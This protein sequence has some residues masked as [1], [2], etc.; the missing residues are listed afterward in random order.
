MQPRLVLPCCGLMMNKDIK[1]QGHGEN[2]YY[3]CCGLMMNKDI[4]QH[5]PTI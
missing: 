2:P 3:L 5:L 1:Q 4:K